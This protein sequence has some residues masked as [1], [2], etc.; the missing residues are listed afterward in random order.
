MI[1]KV[2]MY[3]YGLCTQSQDRYSKQQKSNW[4]KK[5]SFN[6]AQ[7]PNYK[8]T[9]TDNVIY[10][11]GFEKIMDNEEFQNDWILKVHDFMVKDLELPEDIAINYISSE[12][13]LI[14]ELSL[15][16]KDL[17][18]QYLDQGVKKMKDLEV[19]H[20]GWLKQKIVKP[21]DMEKFTNFRKNYYD[22]FYNEKFKIDRNIAN[23]K[24]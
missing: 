20:L 12:G 1:G 9:F 7:T 21:L 13:A 2:S 23:D 19:V 11:V 5:H 14:K 24:K 8:T 6:P 10:T 4:K 3:C 17:H 18:P 16:K 22:I 15:A